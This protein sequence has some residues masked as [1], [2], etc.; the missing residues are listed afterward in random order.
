MGLIIFLAHLGSFVPAELAFIG[1]V[2][3]IFCRMHSVGSSSETKSLFCIDINQVS[4]MLRH[5][6]DAS[7]LLV[8]EFGKG[9]ET[10]GGAAL[11]GAVIQHVVEKGHDA[12]MMLCSTHY[13]ELFEHR[14]IAGENIRMWQMALHTAAMDHLKSTTGSRNVVFLYK[15]V[16]GF[17]MD[18]YASY[19]AQRAGLPSHVIERGEEVA[20]K[21]RS[22]T[23]KIPLK[24]TARQENRLRI[25]ASL[26]TLFSAFDEDNGDIEQFRASLSSTGMT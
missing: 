9:T 5:C 25:E 14:V 20:A 3:A 23:K 2:D 17:G 15:L 1:I 7:L 26:I 4:T 22:A 16:A 18:S 10:V 21:I 13:H 8:D 11:L 6:T 12:P 24:P 19:I